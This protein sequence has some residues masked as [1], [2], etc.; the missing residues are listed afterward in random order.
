MNVQ[1][2]QHRRIVIAPNQQQIIQERIVYAGSSSVVY[3]VGARTHCV[4][5]DQDDDVT[6]T[7]TSSDITI[8][9][10]ADAQVTYVAVMATAKAHD[11]TV[12]IMLKGTRA[13]AV[14]RGVYLLSGEQRVHIR[15]RQEHQAAETASDL[16]FKGIVAGKAQV[17]YEGMIHIAHDGCRSSADQQN[18]TILM[19]D[20]ASAQSIPALEVLTHDVRCAHGSAI[21][22]LDQEHLL[23]L[24]SRGISMQAARRLLLKGF[25][26]DILD[27]LPNDTSDVL[28]TR[29][30]EKIEAEKSGV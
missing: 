18:K 15:T 5:I 26:A 22:Q 13:R 17:I 12:R 20:H 23:Y 8:M 11:K 19:G 6:G 29:M 16:L 3:Q 27:H 24:Q 9:C 7:T 1:N 10:D 28:L 25:L 30:M 21:G 2:D 4:I 14:V